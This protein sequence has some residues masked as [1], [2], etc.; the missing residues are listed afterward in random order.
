MSQYQSRSRVSVRSSANSASSSSIRRTS[1]SIAAAEWMS[2]ERAKPLRRNLDS[3][4]KTG[5]V[6][7]VEASIGDLGAIA[8]VVQPCG[9]QQH[10]AVGM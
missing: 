10:V 7:R 3:R 8:D 2:D 9:A 1:A 6:E 5:S 4:R